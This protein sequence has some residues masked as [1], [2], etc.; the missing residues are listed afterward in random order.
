MRSQLYSSTTAQWVSR[1]LPLVLFLLILGVQEKVSAQGIERESLA[2]ESAEMANKGSD[3]NQPYNLQVGPVTLRT[4]ASVSTSYN[5]NISIAHTGRQGD[6]I[7]IPAL[8][9]HALW[10]ATDLNAL[11][12]DLG[13][14]YQW[15]TTHSSFSSVYVTPN[16]AA[17]FN[18][19]TGDFKINLH[20][21]F[22]YSSNPILVGQLSNIN[23]FPV[24]DNTAGFNVDWDL[25]DII[26]SLGYDHQNQWVYG[27]SYN[28]LTYQTDTVTPKITFEVSKTI[29]AGLVVALSS[30]RYNQNVL[31]NNTSIQAGPFVKAQLTE[32]LAVDAQLGGDFANYNTGGSSNSTQSSLAGVYASAGVSHRINDIFSETFTAGRQFIP[33]VNSNYTQRIYANYGFNWQATNYFTVGTNLWW[34]NLADSSGAYGQNANRYG[35]GL[36]LAYNI[37][38]RSNL[39]LSYDYVLKDANQSAYSYSQNVVTLK[40]LYRF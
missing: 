3:T 2:G 32:N 15:Y 38:D 28:Y 29:D 21:Q 24:F 12:L 30:M 14:G 36:S 25:N 37:T 9:L 40:Y 18:I 22:S 23:Q 20:D 10:Q 31:N 5:D 6:A 7:I 13:V 8:G 4:D 16:S 39:G 33:G 26:V 17:Q 34:E 19:Y 11:T 35:T 27:S 1:A